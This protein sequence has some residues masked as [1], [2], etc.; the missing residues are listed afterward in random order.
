V[1]VYYTA[2]N[3]P[4]GAAGRYFPL[5]RRR[6]EGRATIDYRMQVLGCEVRIRVNCAKLMPLV[7]D[8][9]AGAEGE[10]V[11][12]GEVAIDL[13]STRDGFA[14]FADGVEE[15]RSRHAADMAR[16]LSALIVREVSDRAEGLTQ[17]RA[18][19]VRVAGKNVLLAGADGSQRRALLI[20]LMVRGAEVCGGTVLVAEDGSVVPL[21]RRI[22]LRDEMLEELPEL[23]EACRGLNRYPSKDG[24]TAF[25]FDPGVTGAPWD[26]RRGR[27]D[28][29]LH[30]EPADGEETEVRESGGVGMAS[31]LVRLTDVTG[32]PRRH[33]RRMMGLVDSCPSRLLVPGDMKGA[34]ETLLRI[35][36]DL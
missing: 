20:D 1:A 33:F 19:F 6:L 10:R 22:K 4:F 27:A 18:G 34:A 11:S 2:E 29:I 23:Q 25:F 3:A 5:K 36:S 24:N 15:Y 21:P 31:R 16:P 12:S 13:L 7:R 17:M 35:C 26:V 9:E 28:L 30:L 8:V 14:L 32:E